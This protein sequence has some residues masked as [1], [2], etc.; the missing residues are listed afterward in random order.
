MP[1]RFRQR[2]YLSSVCYLTPTCPIIGDDRGLGYEQR[3]IPFTMNKG[4]VVGS[5]LGSISCSI[6]DE[7]CWARGTPWPAAVQAVK[8]LQYNSSCAYHWTHTFAVV[9]NRESA[10]SVPEAELSA[11]TRTL[12]IE[13]IANTQGERQCL[14]AR[15]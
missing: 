3:T 6:L 2:F 10:A 1:L 14:I 8:P 4:V 9:E 13:R 5:L 7:V 11:G 15:A 12:P